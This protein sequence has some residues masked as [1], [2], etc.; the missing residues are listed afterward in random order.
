MPNDKHKETL[1]RDKNHAANPP[2]DPMLKKGQ[3]DGRDKH[4]QARLKELAAVDEADA[5]QTAHIRQQNLP[6]K[7]PNKATN[8]S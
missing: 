4:G 5:D 8:N 3:E 1:S 7:Q 6:I 2:G